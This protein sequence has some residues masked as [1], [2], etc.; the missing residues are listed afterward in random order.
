MA[1]KGFTIEDLLEPLNI[2]LNMPPM[3]ESQI[4]NYQERRLSKQE[5]L[6][7]CEYM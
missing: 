5:E 3:R 6:L 2:T 1:D 7:L 4:V